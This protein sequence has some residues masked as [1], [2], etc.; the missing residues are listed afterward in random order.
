VE[1]RALSIYRPWPAPIF[2]K[3]YVDDMCTALQ[4]SS[5]DEFKEYL[6][7]VEPSINKV[8]SGK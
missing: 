6:N 3:R 5:I 4:D 1:E 7:S 8:H 2:W